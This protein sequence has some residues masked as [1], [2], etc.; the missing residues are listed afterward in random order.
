MNSLVHLVQLDCIWEDKAANFDRVR[1]LLFETPPSKDA[2]VVLPEMFSTGF[3]TDTQKTLQGPAKEDEAFLRVVA[4]EYGCYVVGGLISQGFSGKCQ[5]QSVVLSPSGDI[6][7][8]YVK[9][10]PFNLGGEGAAHEAG[11][12][13]MTFQWAGFRVAPFVCYDLRFPELA[14]HATLHEGAEVLIYI[15][16]WPIKRYQHWLTLLQ[17]RAIENLAYVIGV[18]RCG[19]DPNFSYAGRSVVV[20]PHGVIIA[21]ASGHEQVITAALSSALVR[22]WRRDFPALD[23][24]QWHPPAS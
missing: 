20:D 11:K 3:S 2:L 7:T 5:N 21:D 13:V 9:I 10:Q 17:A 19:T 15:A 6:L 23:D 16:S 12:E 8:R 18:N 1:Q 14:R 22:D 4:L 24:A